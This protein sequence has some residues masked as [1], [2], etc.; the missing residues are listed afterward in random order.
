MKLDIFVKTL[1]KNINNF[2]KM[3][4]KEIENIVAKTLYKIGY[5]TAY[6]TMKARSLIMDLLNKLDRPDLAT[7]LTT[8]IYEHWNSIQKR[9]SDQTASYISGVK[10]N[11][12][13]TIEDWGFGNQAEGKLS[14]NH[15]RGR[16][17]KLQTAMVD[18]TVDRVNNDAEPEVRTEINKMVT[19]IIK[20]IE[21]RKV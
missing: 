7:K 18:F 6:D 8:N 17:R 16:D 20:L 11:Y 12:Y 1:E 15:P 9:D 14:E 4:E 19:K 5:R 10:G 2:D 13:A 21:C 3:L